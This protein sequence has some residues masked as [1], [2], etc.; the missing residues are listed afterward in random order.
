MKFI[1]VFLFIFIPT[2]LVAEG[3]KA[4]LGETFV[5]DDLVLHE[6]QCTQVSWDSYGYRKYRI[7]K[8]DDPGMDCRDK[9]YTLYTSDNSNYIYFRCDYSLTTYL[10]EGCLALD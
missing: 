8:D 1:S 7:L 2:T 4:A 10:A 9:G 5:V 6:G 3:E